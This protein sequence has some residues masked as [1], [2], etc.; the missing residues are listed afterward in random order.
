MTRARTVLKTGVPGFDALLGGGIPERQALV[1]TGQPGTGKTVLASQVAFHSASKGHRVVMATTTSESQSKLL[2]DLSGFSFFSSDR[3][4]EE[5]FFLSVYPWLKKGP[6][7][8]KEILLQTVRERKAKLLIVDGLRSVRDLWQDEAKLREFFYELSVGLAASE[9]TA[10]FITEYPLKRLIEYAES[11]TVDG[12]VALSVEAAGARRVR[13]AE[14]VKLRG[15]HHLQGQHVMTMDDEGVRMFPRIEA[16]TAPD[17]AHLPPDAR[18]AFDLP[19]LDALLHGGVP[20]QS[21][22]LLAGGGGVGKT[23]LG[24][25]FAAAGARQGEHALFLSFNEP[26]AVLIGRADRVNLSLR[27]E[28]ESGRLTLE[29]QPGLEMEADAL[30]HWL[31]ERMAALGTR[32]LVFEDVDELERRLGDPERSRFFLA[33]L[34]IR[35]RQLKITSLFTRKVSKVIGPEL[36]FSDTPLA[37]LAENLFF[38]RHVE[39]RGRLHR[40]LSILNLRDSAFDASLREFEI[41]DEGLKIREPFDSVEGLL[42]GYARTIVLRPDAGMP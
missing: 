8:A 35:L 19:A 21:S 40:V 2:E 10:L 31:F 24:L 13:R 38:L 28:V 6:R 33:A 32:R 5:L 41:S 14:V 27:P 3:V 17:S 26:S 22:V 9:C 15:L 30:V 18:A 39:L 23:L 37:G 7:E 4:G 1:L 29:Y 16:T 12:I 34:L 25:H 42:T 36:D 11:T 20:V